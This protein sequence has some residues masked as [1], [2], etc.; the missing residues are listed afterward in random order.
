MSKSLVADTGEPKEGKLARL[1]WI[2]AYHGAE[3]R[4]PGCS[5]PSV[6]L[7]MGGG[8]GQAGSANRGEVRGDRDGRHDF[9]NEGP[10]ELFPASM[11]PACWHSASTSIGGMRERVGKSAPMVC[12]TLATYCGLA[13][14]QS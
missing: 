8:T 7:A 4:F 6:Q 3:N 11:L 1:H 12:R 9:Q 14:V 10:A 13:A 5:N 2:T